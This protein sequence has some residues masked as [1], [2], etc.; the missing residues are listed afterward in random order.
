MSARRG[1]TGKKFSIRRAWSLLM[2][3]RLRQ[4]WHVLMVALSEA[5]AAR[6]VYHW[7]TATFV[8]GLRRSGL[9]APMVLDGAMNGA[10]FRAYTEQILVPELTPG[11]VVIMDNL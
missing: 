5:L 6:Q 9:M 11:D 4:P 10:L 3:P 7:Q 2:R 8:G 1:L